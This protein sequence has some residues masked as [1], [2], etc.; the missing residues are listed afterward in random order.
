MTK[1][2]PE[3][4]DRFLHEFKRDGF[5][6]ADILQGRTV[7]RR[8]ALKVLAGVPWQHIPAERCAAVAGLAGHSRSVRLDD[9]LTVCLWLDL[10]D[11]A[12]A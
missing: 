9:L 1:Q 12:A 3:F 8:R 11:R 4:T 2:E 5:S 7:L 10:N 6:R